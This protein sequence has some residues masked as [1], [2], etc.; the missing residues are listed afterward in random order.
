MEGFLWKK[1]GSGSGAS[2]LKFGR[3]NWT[4]RFCRIEAAV[5]HGG[6]SGDALAYYKLADGEGQPG[7]DDK[8]R[9]FVPL[10]AAQVMDAEIDGKTHCF[11]IHRGDGQMVWF[12][13]EAA[14]DKVKWLDGLDVAT[15]GKSSTSDS[16][17]R[18]SVEELASKNQRLTQEVHS[19]RTSGSL[20]PED[21]AP[22]TWGDESKSP[23]DSE[24]ESILTPKSGRLEPLRRGSSGSTVSSLAAARAA[25][26]Q[27]EVAD[28]ANSRPSE[29]VDLDEDV[30]ARNTLAETNIAR[31][32][33]RASN[34]SNR[35]SIA[36]QEDFKF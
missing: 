34:D 33:S 2:P 26:E 35:I 8:P 18:Q 25:L 36:S 23:E 4:R 12:R 15:G 5:L 11:A 29:T 31:S 6:D 19:F 22:A 3:R 32:T 13:A 9:G 20:G 7:P 1:G 27:L 30:V 14:S 28:K 10:K 21:R 17:L 24:V 16:T